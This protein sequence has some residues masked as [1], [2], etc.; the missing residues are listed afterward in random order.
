M[1]V[2]DNQSIG[3]LREKV[4]AWRVV[5][6]ENLANY[7]EILR[8]LT[9]LVDEVNGHPSTSVKMLI[10]IKDVLANLPG[11]NIIDQSNIR[12][13]RPAWL[14]PWWL[15]T[16]VLGTSVIST[17]LTLLFFNVLHLPVR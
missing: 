13:P 1:P 8:N 10:E 6:E 16:I 15:I 14:N 3:T 17:V 11:M 7:C 12:I 9:F 4:D 2:L 5:E